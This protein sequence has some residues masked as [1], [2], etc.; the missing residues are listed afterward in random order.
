MRKIRSN[1]GSLTVNAFSP[2]VPVVMVLTALM[3]WRQAWFRVGTVP[4][5]YAAS[6]CCATIMGVIG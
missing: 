3:L 4:R 1:I 5:A 6:R 2:L